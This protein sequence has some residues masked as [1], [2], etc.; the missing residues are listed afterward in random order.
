MITMILVSRQVLWPCEGC[1]LIVALTPFPVNHYGLNTGM[2]CVFIQLRDCILKTSF[3][4]T[5]VNWSFKILA[6]FT[7]SLQFTQFAV[8]GAT[9]LALHFL[10]LMKECGFF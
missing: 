5:E 8:R 7:L 9:P 3:V 6:F 10:D 2:V 4:K 1:C